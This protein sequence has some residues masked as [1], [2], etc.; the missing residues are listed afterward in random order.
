MWSPNVF[1]ICIGSGPGMGCLQFFRISED[2]IRAFNS[3]MEPE[4]QIDFGK[5][6][7]LDTWYCLECME[8]VAV[9]GEK[10]GDR[11]RSRHPQTG[12]EKEGVFT[13][14]WPEHASLGVRTDDGRELVVHVTQ[15]VLA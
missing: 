3:D 1:G 10:I 8:G 15:L 5:P 7:I 9:E 4:A 13:R 14:A 6:Q 2:A 12:V 11:L